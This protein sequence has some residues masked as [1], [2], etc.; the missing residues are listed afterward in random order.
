MTVKNLAFVSTGL[1][2][3]RFLAAVVVF[4]NNPEAFA[5][6]FGSATWHSTSKADVKQVLWDC[7]TFAFMDFGYHINMNSLPLAAFFWR[8]ARY[9]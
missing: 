7:I 9:G 5:A 8:Q 4:Y 2:I 6:C 3:N 1:N